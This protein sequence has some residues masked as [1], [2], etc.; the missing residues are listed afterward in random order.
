MSFV[1]KVTLFPIEIVPERVPVMSPHFASSI[2]LIPFYFGRF[3][4]LEGT[5]PGVV[6]NIILT[7]PFGFGINF[8]TFI[9]P[10]NFLWLSV[11]VGLAIE[12]AQLI[13]SLCLGYAYRVID[14][15][16][17]ICNAV[18]VLIGYGLFRLFAGAYVWMNR[19]F[20]LKPAGLFGYLLEICQL[21]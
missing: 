14:I 16:D 12:T 18:G 11:L 7:M 5:L 20:K 15:N 9:K 4:S 10:R 19:R 3:A 13:I 1:L 17:V 8:L 6:L 21:K 2:N